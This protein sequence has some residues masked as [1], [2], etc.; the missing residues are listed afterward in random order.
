MATRTVPRG[1]YAVRVYDTSRPQGRQ[2]EQIKA[3][4]AAAAAA[5]AELN[6]LAAERQAI[7]EQQR[8]QL[9]AAQ[10]ESLK[11]QQ[12]QAARAEQLQAAQQL[13]ISQIQSF[14]SA[15]SQ[16][17]RILGGYAGGG[18]QGPTASMTRRKPG[19]AGVSST[20]A[21]LRIGT[22]GRSPG[23]GANLAT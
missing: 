1:D 5:Q 22:V 17:L 18:Q 3:E 20:T 12:E 16:S 10:A 7:A 11:I 8:Q 9:A 2:A 4:E 23:S 19:R 21:S 15:V 14:G 6:R 13:R